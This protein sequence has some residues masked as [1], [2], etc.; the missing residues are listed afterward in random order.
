MRASILRLSWKTEK[1][2]RT[3][4]DLAE[5]CMLKGWKKRFYT[6]KIFDVLS[7]PRLPGSPGVHGVYNSTLLVLYY[8]VM[9]Y[10]VRSKNWNNS[11]VSNFFLKWFRVGHTQHYQYDT[12]YLLLAILV[13]FFLKIFTPFHWGWTYVRNMEKYPIWL[14]NK[15]NNFYL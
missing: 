8:F 7:V 14:D 12:D 10:V 5:V 9:K 2:R 11:K 1:I 6:F 15:Y 13:W 3:I 4:N